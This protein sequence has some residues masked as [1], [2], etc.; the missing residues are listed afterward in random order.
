M[1][2]QR[3]YS[4]PSKDEGDGIGFDLLHPVLSKKKKKRVTGGSV[5]GCSLKVT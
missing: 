3:L 2:E 4:I 1:N 5:A